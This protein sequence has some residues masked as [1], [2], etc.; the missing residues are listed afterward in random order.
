MP[1]SHYEILFDRSTQTN[2]EYSNYKNLSTEG[3]FGII[4]FLAI[5]FSF[6]FPQYKDAL[7]NFIQLN[8]EFTNKTSKF[9]VC[10]RDI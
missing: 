1:N 9:Y 3:A 2:R 8:R 5:S 4:F 6:F 10:A 7:R